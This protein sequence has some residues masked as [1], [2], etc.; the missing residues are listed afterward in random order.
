MSLERDSDTAID[1]D[2]S[3][4]A[5]VERAQEDARS[6]ELLAR[7]GYRSVKAAYARQLRVAPGVDTFLGLT[8]EG[9]SP[10]MEL[11]ADW[12]KAQ[13]KQARARVKWTFV[14]AMVITIV[15]GASFGAF[16]LFL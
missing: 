3:L 12:L 10:T 2:Q 15:A 4:P 16:F 5:F 8:H 9:L 6:R 14:G 7:I 1:A 11:V 13:K